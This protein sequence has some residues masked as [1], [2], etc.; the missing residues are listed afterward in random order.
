VPWTDQ[1]GF[2]L[3]T[4]FVVWHLVRTRRMPQKA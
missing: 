4:A 3:C 2:A 1:V